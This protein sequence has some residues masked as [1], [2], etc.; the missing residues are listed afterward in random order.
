MDIS[1]WSISDGNYLIIFILVAQKQKLNTSWISKIWQFFFQC[2]CRRGGVWTTSGVVPTQ[3]L[4]TSFLRGLETWPHCGSLGWSGTHY[5]D[6]DDLELLE[7][8]SALELKAGTAIPNFPSPPKIFWDKV[9]LL[10]FLP[11]VNPQVLKL[12][13]H[14]L[15]HSWECANFHIIE[16]CALN[17]AFHLLNMHCNC[18]LWGH[19]G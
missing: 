18:R 10:G 14:C 4:S 3:L 15:R 1:I 13:L 11:S 9:F 2:V 7:C 8:P 6:Q 16:M 19:N 5:I 17:V 12:W